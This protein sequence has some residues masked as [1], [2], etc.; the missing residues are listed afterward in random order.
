[1][2]KQG[3]EGW[4]KERANKLTASNVAAALGLNPYMSRQKLWRT[5]M[6]IEPPFEGNEMTRYGEDHEED[7]AFDYEFHMGVMTEETGFWVHPVHDWIGASPDRLVVGQ[8]GLIEIK[9]RFDQTVWEAVPEHY[10]PQIQTQLE[11]TRRDWC[12]F[13][14]WAPTEMAIYRVERSPEY[15]KAIFPKLETFWKNIASMEQPKRARKAVVPD[16]NVKRIY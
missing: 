8:P 13:V 11:V 14:S 15:W 9:C 1:M 7:A 16:V 12:D 6:G 4:H 5:L 10:M 3:S 2:H